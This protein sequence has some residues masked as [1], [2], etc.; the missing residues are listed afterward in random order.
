[1]NEV[2]QVSSR[3]PNPMR[4]HDGFKIGVFC[5]LHEGGLTMTKIPERWKADWPD[6]VA[7]AKLADS[8]KLDFLLPVARWKGI[9]GD[10]LRHRDACYEVL[11]H[12]AALAALT[13]HIAIFSTVHVPVVHPIHAAKAMVTID[14]VS[15]GRSG[16]NIVCGWDPDDLGMFGLPRLTHEERYEQGWEWYQIWSKLVVG[17][18]DEFDF[19]GKFFKNQRGLYA[20]PGCLQQ[21]MPLVLSAAT[22]QQ[23]R[24]YAVKTSDLLFTVAET[25]E[26]A[27][28]EIGDIKA[29]A[30]RMGRR[31]PMAVLGTGYVVCRETRSE[32]EEFEKYYAETYGDRIATAR[33]AGLRAQN[34]HVNDA[35]YTHR[36]I[37]A[38]N[39]GHRLV[40]TP[41]DV[42]EG[43]Y[44]MHKAGFAGTTVSFVDF[45]SELA[46]FNERVMPIID[47]MN[48]RP[49]TR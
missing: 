48:I 45:V 3:F 21:P 18:R 22:S 31:R 8:A 14:H 32:A 16:L 34:A 28:I 6:I 20:K 2:T 25:L 10:G 5:Y 13:S 42:A 46:F 23:G 35:L 19:D 44:E 29:L 40:G 7:M 41:Q 37:A 47:R 27:T 38:G 1:M 26:Q 49:A 33:Y 30:E 17:C 11:T 15:R 36:R 39:A 12:A 24:E 9:P 4:D 43:L